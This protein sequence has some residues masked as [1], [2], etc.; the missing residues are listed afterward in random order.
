LFVENQ[1]LLGT[2][3]AHGRLTPSLSALVIISHVR[4]GV[5]LARR[6]GLPRALQEIIEEHHGTSLCAYF[7]HQAKERQ[8]AP[9]SEEH[10]RYDGR[11][12]RSKESGI[13][14]LADTVQAAAQSLTDPSPEQLESLVKSLIAERLKDG[15]LEE[16][17]L[18]FRELKLVT[19]SFLRNLQSLHLHKRVEY[20]TLMRVIGDRGTTNQELPAAPPKSSRAQT[21]RPG[22]HGG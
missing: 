12:P 3:N 11:K 17:E 14:M 13:I 8:G 2:E 20:P 6:H 7:Y 16:C 4:D 5:E 21:P 1:Y 22:R 9:P 19:E 10:F 15:Q 18:T